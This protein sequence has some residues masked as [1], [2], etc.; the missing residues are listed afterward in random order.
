MSEIRDC[1]KIS[2]KGYYQIIIREEFVDF[3][4]WK[5][6]L[7]K[8]VLTKYDLDCRGQGY[9]GATNMSGPNGVQGRLCSINSKAVYVH[10]NS[11][12]LNLCVEACSLPPIR[13]MNSTITETAYFFQNSAKRQLF[14]E[15]LL[16]NRTTTVKV[17][18]LCRTRWIDMRHMVHL[19][20]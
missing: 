17:K 1:K 4:M 5:G 3:I 11:H 7:S 16:D 12:V 6:L 18:D 15:K 8:A 14:L 20:C 9:D 19:S 2:A 10:C 13:N